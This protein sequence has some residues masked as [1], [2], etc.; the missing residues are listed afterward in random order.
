MLY[1]FLSIVSFLIIFI[2]PALIF[3]VRLILCKSKIRS[4][5]VAFA[6]GHF[7]F[8]S[9]IAVSVYLS[10][11]Q[12]QFQL[13]WLLAFFYD[14]PIAWLCSSWKVNA[15]I[16]NFMGDS[17]L[18]RYLFSPFLFHGIFGTFQYYLIG[19]IIDYYKIMRTRQY[20]T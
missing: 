7:A 16:L 6:L 10:Q 15:V 9:I 17:Y 11:Y 4:L 12:A 2:L 8:I 1:I 18:A 19:R 3:L 20:V 5:G 13:F 14:L